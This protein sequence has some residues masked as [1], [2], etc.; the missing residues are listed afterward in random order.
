MFQ[1]ILGGKAQLNLGKVDETSLHAVRLSVGSSPLS[2]LAK[3]VPLLNQ[4]NQLNGTRLTQLIMCG[5]GGLKGCHSNGGLLN[6]L[7]DELSYCG[8]YMPETQSKQLQA[9]L[10]NMINR[11]SPLIVE[12]SSSQQVPQS[13]KALWGDLHPQSY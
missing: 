5:A 12:N 1:C 2:C 6:P 11:A 13:R 4:L 9:S 10:T 7:H 3:H 8:E